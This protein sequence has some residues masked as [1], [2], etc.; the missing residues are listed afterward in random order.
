M[1]KR[2]K[3][4][5]TSDNSASFTAKQLLRQNQSTKLDVI[6]TWFRENYTDPVN[7]CP[8][9]DGGYDYI[10]GGPYDALEVLSYEFMDD[11]YTA[12]IEMVAGELNS[13]CSFWSPEPTAD[14]E[15]YYEQTFG[16][17]IKLNG[18]YKEFEKSVFDISEL[19]S[20]KTDKNHKQ[21]FYRLV[22]ASVISA[23]E[24]YLASAFIELVTEYG[25]FRSAYVVKRR[26]EKN[27][28]KPKHSEIYSQSASRSD[29]LQ[30]STG[31]NWHNLEKT[32]KLYHDFLGVSFP[33]YVSAFKNHIYNRHDIVHRNG[34]NQSGEIIRFKKK[35]IKDLIKLTKKFGSDIN[36]LI[37]MRLNEPDAGRIDRNDVIDDSPF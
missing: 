33:K 1:P 28:K 26:K 36:K 9:S 29:R 32:E 13:E 21:L 14:E 15:E 37:E 11:K 31:H 10:W 18:F 22:Y 35:D 16:E 7:C 17:Q 3:P 24:A 23:L 20:S 19:L 30:L 34:K 12:L 8:Y 5:H 27:K 4:Y 6:E 25:K 2:N